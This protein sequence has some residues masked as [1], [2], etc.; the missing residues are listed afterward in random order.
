ME[1]ARKLSAKQVVCFAI[2]GHTSREK[3][4]WYAMKV[5]QNSKNTQNPVFLLITYR[6]KH[7]VATK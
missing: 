6:I 4:V 1:N 2:F 5:T 3:I 7:L